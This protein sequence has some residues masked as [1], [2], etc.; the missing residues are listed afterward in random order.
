M[1]CLAKSLEDFESQVQK[2]EKVG[3]LKKMFTNNQPRKKLE[4]I[5]SELHKDIEFFVEIIIQVE[6]KAADK[7]QDED[8]QKTTLRLKRSFALLSAS[9]SH[10]FISLHYV[11]FPAIL[12]STLYVMPTAHRSQPRGITD[13]LTQPYK[14]IPLHCAAF[15]QSF[16]QQP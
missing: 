1:K 9:F 13:S 14:S 11:P 2:M 8:K 15:S 4:K 5:N 16:I 3:K 6:V 10:S 7:Q 12:C